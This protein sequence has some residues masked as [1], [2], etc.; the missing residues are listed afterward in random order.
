MLNER[1]LKK[2]AL[3]EEFADL[4]GR[5]W[6]GRRYPGCYEVIQLYAKRELG[7]DLK[8]FAGLYTSFKDEAVAEENGLWITKPQWGE[9]LDFSVIKKN[10]LLL[11]KIYT[12]S[13]GGGYSTK[14]ADRAPNHGA[15]YLGDGFIL[16]QVWQ[17]PSNI[18]DLLQKGSYL[19]QHSCVGVIREN[20]T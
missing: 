14:M 8:S 15:V 17:Q 7:R 6:P 3:E 13:L 11:Y 9:P 10:D 5:P 19:Y 18:V 20:A 4:V 16:H 12:D 1:Q 2:K